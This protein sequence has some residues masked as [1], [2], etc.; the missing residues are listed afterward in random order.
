MGTGSRGD[1]GEAPGIPRGRL[2]TGKLRGRFEGAPGIPQYAPRKMESPAERISFWNN[3][4]AALREAILSERDC[5]LITVCLR[6]AELHCNES[7]SRNRKTNVDWTSLLMCM[8]RSCLPSVATNGV[9][10]WFEGISAFL[11]SCRTPRWRK[12]GQRRPAVRPTDPT[13]HWPIGPPCGQPNDKTACAC[14]TLAQ[15]MLL[16]IRAS[17]R[18]H[19]TLM[20]IRSTRVI[21]QSAFSC[22]ASQNKKVCVRASVWDGIANRPNRRRSPWK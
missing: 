18:A 4:L 3:A 5:L 14:D 21:V 2:K 13:T 15:V 17:T 20:R 19:S 16:R 8:I 1:S 9:P 7:R 22:G 10:N 12:R 6:V 11:E